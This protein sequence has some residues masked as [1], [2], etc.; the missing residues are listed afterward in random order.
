VCQAWYVF[1]GWKSL[2]RRRT[3]GLEKRKGVV[4]RLGLK[5]AWNKAAR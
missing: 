2:S 3:E 5:E 4:A 1:Y